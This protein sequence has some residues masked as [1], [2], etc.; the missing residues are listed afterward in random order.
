M[1]EGHDMINKKEIEN[2]LGRNCRLILKNGFVFSGTVSSIEENSFFFIDKKT[3]SVKF[4]Y[5][6]IDHIEQVIA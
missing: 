1:M 2:F 3:G 4:D 5:E 6:A